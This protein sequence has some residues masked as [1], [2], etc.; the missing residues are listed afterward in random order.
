MVMTT[1]LLLFG[2]GW[3]AALSWL[4][5][6]AQLLNRLCQAD[7]E[8]YGQ[9]KA[10]VMR[11]LWWQWPTTAPS[12]PPRLW[13]HPGG[14]GRLDLRSDYSI[15]DLG[16]LALTLRWIARNRPRASHDQSCRKLRQRLRWA[17][18]TLLLSLGSMVA[19]GLLG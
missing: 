1:M 14:S 18:A 17:A 16:G 4:V 6:M 19:L 7:P 9:L 2:V 8:L 13:I 3:L 12:D 15:D 5:W 11:W 10:P